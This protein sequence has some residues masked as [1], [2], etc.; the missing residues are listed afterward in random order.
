MAIGKIIAPPI[1]REQMPRH[2]AFIM[3]GN[4]RWA[5]DRNLPRAEGHRAGSKAMNA[6]GRYAAN[7]GIETVTFYAFSTENWKRSQEEVGALML[8][9]ENYL[10]DMERSSDENARLIILGDLSRLDARLQ[11]KI[12][13]VQKKTAGNSGITVNVAFN[14]GGRD[15]LVHG[16]RSLA[17]QCVGGTLSPDE[18]DEAAVTQ[19]LYTAGQQDPDMIIRPSGEMRLSNFLLWQAAYAELVFMNVLWPDFT[20]KHLDDAIREYGRRDRRFG[21]R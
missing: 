14:Y 6:I 17:Q 18:I 11:K 12:L 15:E 21:G 8:L 9:M 10:D 16:I 19:S 13:S 3:D 20:P 5:N 1:P 2:I 4:G 7:L